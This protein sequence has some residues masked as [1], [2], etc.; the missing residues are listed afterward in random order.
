MQQPTLKQWIGFNFSL[1]GL[2][3]LA[4]FATL[5]VDRELRVSFLDVGQGDSILI[6]TPEHRT[7]LIDAGPDSRVVDELGKQMGF[8][9]K[10]I[11]LFIL[12]HPDS[13][14]YGGVVDV[15][16]KYDIESVLTTGI[17]GRS[18]LYSNFL[19]A[20]EREGS[21][22]LYLDHEQDLQIGQNLY[23]DFLYPFASQNWMGQSPRNKNNNSISLRLVRR[24]AVGLEPIAILTGDAEAPQERELLLSGQDLTARIYKVGHH[25]SRT[26]SLPSFLSTIEAEVAVVS[27]GR[28]NK[29]GHPHPEVMERLKNLEV[30]R[31][32]REGT[33]VLEP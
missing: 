33:I 30:Q 22:W 5:D 16:K 7:I 25:G 18:Q 15:F 21:K 24:T 20:A 11:D 31:T 29:Y 6:Q 12:T 23:L 4:A 8:F 1:L 13:D 3:C 32:D 27:A 28:E 2:I 14:H 17:D 19:M 10:Q 9:D 26:S